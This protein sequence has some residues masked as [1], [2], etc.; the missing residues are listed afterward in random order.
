M[1]WQ[2]M[3]SRHCCLSAQTQAMTTPLQ[4]I[5]IGLRYDLARELLDT[6]PASVS[7]LEIH[8]ENYMRRG[9]EYP[10]FL[11]E[12]RSTWPIGTHGLTMCF[13]SPQPFAQEYLKDLR[14]FLG[15]LQVDWHSDH[16]CFGG[17]HGQYVHDLLPIPFTDEAAALA[18]ERFEQARDSLGLQ[19][20]LENV[21]YYAAQAEDGLEEAAFVNEVLE[22][23]DG[24]LLL[25]VNNVYVNSKNFGFDPRAF[26]DRMPVERVV[27]IHVAGHFIREDEIRIDTHGESI[28]EDVYEL[29]DYTLRRV[30]RV[31]VLLERDTEIPPLGDLLAEV[32]RLNEIYERACGAA[33]AE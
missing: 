14:R 24:R 13:G 29:L 30:G 28:C 21:S 23:T 20:A 4:G 19:L 11:E 32:D 22:R 2:R 3:L 16:L 18:S 31:P 7:W 1:P 33:N 17:A 5:G 12:A 26:I 15:E 6:K 25:D 9:G 27:Q 8:P 10:A